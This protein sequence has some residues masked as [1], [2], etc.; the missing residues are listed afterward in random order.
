MHETVGRPARRHNALPWAGAVA[1]GVL[2]GA[3]W[4]FHHSL[5]QMSA[6]G[7]SV[8]HTQEVLTHLEGIR[9]SLSAAE[10]ARR[11]F[12]LTGDSDELSRFGEH[13][14]S[15]SAHLLQARR[16]TMGNERQ[17][18]RFDQ[19][20]PLV[21]TRIAQLRRARDR[22]DGDR[23]EKTIIREGG[24]LMAK[25]VR[26]L[27]GLQNEE[28]A[29]L[30]LRKSE[31]ARL[32]GVTRTVAVGGLAAGG[33]LLAV[34]VH[35]LRRQ[36]LQRESFESSLVETVQELARSKDSL[37]NQ[38]QILQSMID[39]MSEGVVVAD[40]QGRFVQFNPAAQRILGRSSME[41]TPSAWSREYGIFHPDG[42]PFPADELPLARAIR[43]YDSTDVELLV[44]NPTVPE[45]A[46]ILVNGRP[47]RD[48]QGKLRGGIVVFRDVTAGTR[49]REKHLREIATLSEMGELLQAC[50][51]ADEA[52]G[53]LAA[54]APILFPGFSGSIAALRASRNV[55]ETKTTWGGRP[56]APADG[57][58]EIDACWA[59]RRGQPHAAEGSA[60]GP[61]CA[62]L[63]PASARSVC[64]PLGAEADVLGV[65]SLV[66]DGE[67]AAVDADLRRLLS[68]VARQAGTS[69]GNLRLRE[70][71]KNQSIR[72]GL[73]GL[74]NRRF[75]EEFLERESFRAARSGA[76]FGVVLIDVDHFKRFND[77]HGHEAG[78][79]VLRAIGESLRGGV[80]GGDVACRYGGEELVVVL[81]GATLEASRARAEA[82]R[83]R[84]RGLRIA[85]RGELLGPVTVSM[86]VAAFPEHGTTAQDVVAAADRALYRAKRDGR[87]RVAT[88]ATEA[89]ATEGLPATPRSSTP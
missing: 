15:A 83:E 66:A 6:S 26:L 89:A 71:L 58:F 46:L 79:A 27:E 13:L 87:D 16:L 12:A 62:H 49:A 65:F 28:R 67:A 29:L 11:A 9:A 34:V 82:L 68:T 76:P 18:T 59:L 1:L 60:A 78:D 24:D 41:L 10:S 48:A 42:R 70:I 23:D 17:Q 52:Y 75:L 81:P 85:P 80:R 53:I 19:L 14:A 2:A 64:V 61:A 51:T 72:D 32:G 30:E 5:R 3:G 37:A 45:G 40:E 21:T 57:L 63:G 36:I 20:E 54:K 35:L 84:V 25:I 74:Y 43:G 38:T 4:L 73:T 50:H 8:S 33:L 77:T 86:G 22:Q 31:T 88:A 7:E 47:Y 55:L 39:S 56:A 44:R 69:L